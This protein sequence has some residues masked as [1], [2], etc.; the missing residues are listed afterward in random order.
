MNRYK[1]FTLVEL[2]V[3]VMIVAILASVAVPK[4]L[5]FYSETTDAALRHTLKVVRDAIDIYAGQNNGSLPPCT[6]T[7]A[8][9][10]AALD[11]YIRGEFP[12][13]PVGPAPNWDVTPVTGA[14]T[15]GDAAP[16][17]GWKFNTDDAKFICNYGAAV[18]SDPGITYDRL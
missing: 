12:T 18:K 10:R 6:G 13:C 3:V 8:D 7:G 1:G 17:T 2:V 11:F 14:T 5:N 4:L 15:T 16:T 9:F